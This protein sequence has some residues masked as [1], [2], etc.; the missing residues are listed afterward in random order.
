MPS[1]G[2]D[3]AD[4]YSSA[5]S[6]YS[7]APLC[8]SDSES[9]NPTS[10]PGLHP[11]RAVSYESGLTSPDLPKAILKYQKSRSGF[12][13]KAAIF[14]PS[15]D[16]DNR[17]WSSE[18]G[19]TCSPTADIPTTFSQSYDLFPDGSSE[20]PS[21]PMQAYVPRPKSRGS[22]KSPKYRRQKSSPLVFHHQPESTRSQAHDFSQT[23]PNGSLQQSMFDP[24][25]TSSSP[26]PSNHTQHQPQINPYAQDPTTNNSAQYFQTSSYAQ[27]LQYHLYASLGPHRENLLPYQRAAHDFFISDNL[28]EELQRRSAATLQTLP[29]M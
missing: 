1:Q 4:R 13:A 9:T 21:P 10:V 15:E 7:D 23:D 22:R 8:P 27:P 29:S 17:R 14:K 24:Y 26:L 5:S 12:N 28:R 20:T 11:R 19:I 6:S 3:L 2:R 16:I 18:G 25:L